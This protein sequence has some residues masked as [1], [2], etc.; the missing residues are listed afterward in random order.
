MGFETYDDEAL[1]RI[2]EHWQRTATTPG[3]MGDK[4]KQ[5]ALAEWHRRQQSDRQ[6]RE[7]AG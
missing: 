1:R 6:R 4:A 7:G 2:V 3:S 5:D